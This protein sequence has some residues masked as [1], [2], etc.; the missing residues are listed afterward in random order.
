MRP[1]VG[2]ILRRKAANVAHKILIR[3]E[4]AE[5]VLDVPEEFVA[6]H[7]S[8]RLCH[9]RVQLLF[10]HSHVKIHRDFRRVPLA[11]EITLDPLREAQLLSRATLCGKNE[12]LLGLFWRLEVLIDVYDDLL[13]LMLDSQL[14]LKDNNDNK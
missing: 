7:A 6:D 13:W 1:Q 14:F 5:V 9:N 10:V 3:V 4:H 8:S 12:D 2:G 11:A